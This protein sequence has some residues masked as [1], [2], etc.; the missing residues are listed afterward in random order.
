MN[1]TTLLFEFD[2]SKQTQAFDYEIITSQTDKTI[3]TAL[4]QI[5]DS[6]TFL[7]DETIP[8]VIEN[9]RIIKKNCLFL[10]SGLEQAIVLETLSIFLCGLALMLPTSINQIATYLYQQTLANYQLVS[11][12]ITSEK[13]SQAYISP[14]Y[15]ALRASTSTLVMYIRAFQNH[16][17]CFLMDISPNLVFS[18]LITVDILSLISTTPA[19][20]ILEG[21]YNIKTEAASVSSHR[22]FP[23]PQSLFTKRNAPY[24][25][26]YPR[27]KFTLVL[28]L[29]ETLGHKQAGKFLPRPKVTQ[30]LSEVS[31]SFEIVLFTSASQSYADQALKM[32]DPCNEIKLRL[33]KQHL[34]N[35]NGWPAKDLNVL[36]R[37]LSKC[38]II[39]NLAQYFR[40][41][42][43]NGIEIESFYGNSDDQALVKLQDFLSKIV[44]NDEEDLR[45]SLKRYPL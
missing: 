4:S 31:R 19:E 30:F 42:P 14:L 32:I 21:I 13:C 45:P 8:K 1:S 9:F 12:L 3:F 39:D 29:D 34:V 28:D 25:P 7:S 5:T 38:V 16:T 33:Y 11:T 41:Q 44:L 26:E 15:D 22:S 43:E 6:F 18:I 20:L 24:L 17:T 36:G 10:N 40:L 23:S 2:F 35:E 37:D 27:K